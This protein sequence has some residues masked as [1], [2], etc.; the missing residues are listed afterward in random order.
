MDAGARARGW[1]RGRQDRICDVQRPWAHGTVLRS[2]ANPEYYDFNLVRVEAP[3]ALDADGLRAVADEALGDL[4]HRRLD[5]EVAEAGEA[6]A[7][8]MEALGW[9]PTRLVLL[10]HP[11]GEAPQPGVPVEEV[12]WDEVRHLRAAWHLEDFP[13]QPYEG[14]LEQAREVERA[15]GVRTF[16]T[17]RDGEVAGYADLEVRDGAA[18]VTSVYVVAAHRGGGL[19]TS[20]TCAAIAAAQRPPDLWIAADEADRAQHLYRRLGFEDATRLVSLTRW[21]NAA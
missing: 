5:F 13:G 3:P 15:L 16:V 4:A 14:Y 12:A 19:G 9:K 17:R 11:T 1:L 21:P 2:T 7:P 20:L 18:E 6:V 10:R 8:A